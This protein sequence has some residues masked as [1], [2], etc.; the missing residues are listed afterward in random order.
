MLIIKAI[1]PFEHGSVGVMLPTPSEIKGVRIQGR[2]DTGTRGRGDRNWTGI[3]TLP[4]FGR[5]NLLFRRG[6][7]PLDIHAVRRFMSRVA[8]RRETLRVSP[9]PRLRVFFGQI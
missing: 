9:S 4:N 3:V 5:L 8:C 2:G 1:A 7:K 6:L